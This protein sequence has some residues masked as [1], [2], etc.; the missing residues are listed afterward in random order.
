MY[1]YIFYNIIRNF[2]FKVLYVY[3]ID[4]WDK[5]LKVFLNIWFVSVFK[6]VIGAN[7]YVINI[8]Y[9]LDNYIV[10]FDVMVRE[11]LKFKKV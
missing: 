8:V 11:G 2:I 5:Y 1:L 4:I 7:V 10:W 6:G 3:I 9:Y